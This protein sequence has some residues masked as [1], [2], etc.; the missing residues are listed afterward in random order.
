MFGEVCADFHTDHILSG[1]VLCFFGIGVYACDAF[2][3]SESQ[4]L[5][6]SVLKDSC[7]G[8]SCI[9]QH[10][11]ASEASGG[12]FRIVYLCVCTSDVDVLLKTTTLMLLVTFAQ[13]RFATDDIV[14][15]FVNPN[16]INEDMPFEKMV[17]DPSTGR[18][19]VGGVNNL[20]DLHASGLGVKAHATIGW[21]T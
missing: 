4:S 2:C 12:Y 8:W 14:A 7:V 15:E 11:G 1:I 5:M 13:A 17:I 18:L 9:V 10:S 6:V 3:Q 19:Y 16:N 20:Y 21:E